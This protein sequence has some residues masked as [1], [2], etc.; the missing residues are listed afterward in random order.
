MP[1]AA[2]VSLPSLPL[3]QEE[4]LSLGVDMGVTNKD[5]IYLRLLEQYSY[6]TI[7][8]YDENKEKHV[9]EYK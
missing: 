4:L 6:E 2:Q 5:E 1:V 3:Q 8:F 9:T 7:N